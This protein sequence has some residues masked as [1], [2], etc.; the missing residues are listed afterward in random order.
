MSDRSKSGLAFMFIAMVAW[1]LGYWVM[2]DITDQLH[3]VIKALPEAD[4]S[5]IV[6]KQVIKECGWARSIILMLTTFVFGAGVS[7]YLTGRKPAQG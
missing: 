3:S 2:R 5:V 4:P 7:Y 6:L 1:V